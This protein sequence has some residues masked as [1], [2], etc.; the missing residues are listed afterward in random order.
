MKNKA[1]ISF[2]LTVEPN[3]VSGQG[4][5]NLAM[6]LVNTGKVAVTYQRSSGQR[7]EITAETVGKQ[8]WKWS[9]GRFFTAVLESFTLK[10][11]ESKRFTANWDLTGDS[12]ERVAPGKYHLRAWLKSVDENSPESLSVIL[13]VK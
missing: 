11:G 8:V 6:T 7:F 12:L 10:P 13:D 9:N 5:V 4:N 3:P 1:F 2:E